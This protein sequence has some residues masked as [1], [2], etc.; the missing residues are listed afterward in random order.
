ME[1]AGSGQWNRN[2]SSFP[3]RKRNHCFL[4]NITNKNNKIWSL[5]A[6][7]VLIVRAECGGKRTVGSHFGAIRK[8]NEL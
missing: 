4:I 7:S 5:R 8:I 1:V 2:P 3:G 6:G